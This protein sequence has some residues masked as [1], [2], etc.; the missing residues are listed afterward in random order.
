MPN[1][2]YISIVLE[3]MVMLLGL[4]LATLKLK[5]YGWFIALTFAI[6]V[7]YDLARLI[8]FKVPGNVLTS[9]F[10]IATLSILWAVWQIYLES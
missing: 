4:M 9:L 8:A 2:Q 3:F 5:S 1:L 6:Y 7:F 10:F